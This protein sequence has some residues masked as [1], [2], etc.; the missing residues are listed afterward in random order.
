MRELCR[1]NK[2]CKS[3]SKRLPKGACSVNRSLLSSRIRDSKKLN[4]GW[5]RG[6]NKACMGSRQHSTIQLRR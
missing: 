2:S 1:D 6:A 5:L 3:N 4:N